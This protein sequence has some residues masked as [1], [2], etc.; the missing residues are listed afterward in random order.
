MRDIENPTV[1]GVHPARLPPAVVN[2]SAPRLD[3]KVPA[4]VRRDHH[5]TISVHLKPGGF[6]LIA[7]VSAAGKT[8]LAFE[9]IRSELPSHRLLAP[10]ERADFESIAED[11]VDMRRC[12][13]W[14]D[15]LERFLS[16]GRLTTTAVDR[17]L[18]GQGHRRVI[19]ATIRREE[20][21]ALKSDK[22]RFDGRRRILDQAEIVELEETFTDVELNRAE[23]LRWDPRIDDALR[24]SSNHVPEY[25]AAGPELVERIR[26]GRA[27]QPRG[28]ALVTAAVEC[29]RAGW[30]G[31]LPIE[32]VEQLHS[33]YLSKRYEPETLGQGWEWATTPVP[34]T[35][36]SLVTKAGSNVTVADYLV[37][38]AQRTSSATGFVGE[39]TVRTALDHAGA[40]NIYSIGRT[41][42][43]E[44]RCLLARVAFERV[45]GLR[46][47]TL[48]A[49]HPDTLTTRHSLAGTLRDLGLFEEARAECEAVLKARTD[50]L[51]P[52][53]PST[54][55]TRHN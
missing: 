30:I 33:E 49:A 22:D 45:K 12:V 26:D 8:R 24:N 48:G 7:G 35:T 51:G 28:I 27:I 3:N 15:D 25:L 43:M 17:I 21:S 18:A 40:S 36:T 54:L 47:V 6:V 9:A 29:R 20:L 46:T 4:Y 37:D 42:Q 53:H 10:G 38:H 44:G 41:M 50:L 14:L 23:T 31:P 2:K 32:L 52:E 5:D 13:V 39:S 11:A 16:D 19:V 55:A 34:R 1:L